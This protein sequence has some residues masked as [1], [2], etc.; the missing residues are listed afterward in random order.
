M[1]TFENR[2]FSLIE[3]SSESLFLY[4]ALLLRRSDRIEWFF[5][6]LSNRCLAYFISSERINTSLDIVRNTVFFLN[7]LSYQLQ[8]S[9][10]FFTNIKAFPLLLFIS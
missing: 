5:L 2:N 4:L 3:N 7:C 8:I 1:K 6:E 9:V 10:G